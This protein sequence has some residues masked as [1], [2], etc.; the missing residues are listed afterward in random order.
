MAGFHVA[1]GC[2][3][4]QLENSVYIS[5]S[6]SKGQSNIFTKRQVLC[7]KTNIMKWFINRYSVLILLPSHNLLQLVLQQVL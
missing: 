3:Y 1:V 6:G 7:F 5:I 4:S 2:G